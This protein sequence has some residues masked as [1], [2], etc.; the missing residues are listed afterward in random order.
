MGIDFVV[1]ELLDQTLGLVE[2]KEFGDGDADEG[3][4]VLRYANTT[5][6]N[7]RVSDE[8]KRSEKEGGGRE[9]GR[10]SEMKREEKKNV[11]DP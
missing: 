7:N 8:E 2:G 1:G 10:K 4:F 11:Q 6:N 3:G 9:E 5:K